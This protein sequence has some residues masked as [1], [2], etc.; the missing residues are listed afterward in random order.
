MRI[1]HDDMIEFCQ[2]AELKERQIRF[3][4][5][6]DK[7]FVT[8]FVS[9]CEANEAFNELLTKGYLRVNNFH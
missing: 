4:T 7:M 1:R 8:D 5:V 2:V 6:D 9:I 3:L